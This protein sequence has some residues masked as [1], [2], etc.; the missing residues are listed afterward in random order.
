LQPCISTVGNLLATATGL[1]TQR[2]STILMTEYRVAGDKTRRAHVV[3]NIV[4]YS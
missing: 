1:V 4:G 3:E 2:H